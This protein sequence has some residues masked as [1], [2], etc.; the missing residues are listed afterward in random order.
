MPGFFFSAGLF[1][2][3]NSSIAALSSVILSQMKPNALRIIKIFCRVSSK[4]KEGINCKERQA[5]ID[6]ILF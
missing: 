6:E 5:S 3:L 2:I 1:S 4:E